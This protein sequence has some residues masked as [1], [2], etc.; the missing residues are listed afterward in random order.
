MSLDVR[1][2]TKRPGQ[3]INTTFSVITRMVG[4]RG[5]QQLW[6]PVSRA[7]T[8]EMENVREE[9]LDLVSKILRRAGHQIHLPLH[10]GLIKG[11]TVYLRLEIG[12]AYEYPEVYGHPRA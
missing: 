8:K 7:V 4:C 10:H 9:P 12:L 5:D 3:K 6:V 11:E 1:N 2:S